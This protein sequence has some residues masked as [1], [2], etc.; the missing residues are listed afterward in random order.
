MSVKIESTLAH[1]KVGSGSLGSKRLQNALALTVRAIRSDTERYVPKRTGDLR[2]TVNLSRDTEGLITWEAL[3]KD[4]RGSYAKHVYELDP[5]TTNW[6]T[7]GTTSHWVEVAKPV[8][9]NSWKA[10]MAKGLANG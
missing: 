3:R 9:M 10:I 1:A 5:Y 7:A 8:F 6:T 4:G 2:D